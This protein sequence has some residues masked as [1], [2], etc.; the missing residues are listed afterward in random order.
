MAKGGKPKYQVLHV[1]KKMPSRAA[2][3]R[4]GRRS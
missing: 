4:K 3:S 1:V 2:K